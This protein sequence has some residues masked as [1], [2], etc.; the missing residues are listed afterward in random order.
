M[1]RRC[2]FG[3]GDCRDDAG[4][5]RLGIWCAAHAEVLHRAAV[6]IKLRSRDSYTIHGTKPHATKPPSVPVCRIDGCAK[7]ASPHS[8]DGRGC[9]AHR[10]TAP[11]TT[12]PPATCSAEG[13]DRTAT[14]RGR[15]RDH[16]T[17]A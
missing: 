12:E 15:C 5:G 17:S 7:T 16:P 10:G 1:T 2:A 9:Y 8:T 4:H 11:G 6:E 13:C 14:R 3:R